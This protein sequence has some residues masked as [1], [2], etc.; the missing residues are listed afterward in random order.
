MASIAVTAAAGAGAP[1]AQAEACPGAGPG[2]CPYSSA[3]VI[4]QRA[5]DREANLGA[6]QAFAPCVK[7]ASPRA[8][9][10]Y[11][12]RYDHRHLAAPV[13]PAAAA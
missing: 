7:H 3:R 6:S 12:N 2:P 8:A 1:G 11:V 5:R 13:R 10:A 4:G 9:G